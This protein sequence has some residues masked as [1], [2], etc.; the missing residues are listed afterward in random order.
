MEA[1]VLAGGLGTRLKP[2]ISDIPKPMAPIE[3]KPFLH[4]LFGFLKK[5]GIQKVILST[6]YKHQIIENYF[7]K[8]YL[9]ISIEYSVEDFPLETGGAVKK[10]MELIHSK[11]VFVLN[12]D[13]YFG[14]SLKEL[15]ETH[16]S[17]HSQLTVALKRMKNPKRYGVI[18]TEGNRIVEFHEKNSVQSEGC[19]NGGI[20]VIKPELFDNIATPE[21]FSLEKDFLEKYVRHV[22]MNSCFSDSY[23]IDIGIPEDYLLAQKELPKKYAE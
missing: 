20:Y 14:I 5:N 11:E 17:L 18:E 10:A 15:Y 9:G 6:G 22:R 19:I 1:I 21:K 12:G 3:G 4:Y 13:T 23:F 7:G 8:N 16:I 2:I